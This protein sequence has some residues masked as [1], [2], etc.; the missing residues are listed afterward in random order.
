[1]LGISKA[2]FTAVTCD[3]I[4]AW[5]TCVLLIRSAFTTRDADAR[6]DVRAQ[7]CRDRRLR[8]DAQRAMFARLTVPERHEEEAKPAPGPN[9]RR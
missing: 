7:G 3:A 5:P 8:C 4:S 6:S 2:R 9:Q 1:M